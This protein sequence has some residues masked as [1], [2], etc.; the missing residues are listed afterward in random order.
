MKSVLGLLGIAVG[1]E[2]LAQD[3]NSFFP[4][5]ESPAS[6]RA[7]FVH[8]VLPMHNAMQLDGSGVDI[9]VWESDIP[10]VDHFAFENAAIE[11][12][13]NVENSPGTHATSVVG[14]MVGAGACQ[15]HGPAPGA[16]IRMFENGGGSTSVAT[17][18]SQWDEQLN[19]GSGLL[20]N[21]SFLAGGDAQHQAI[22]TSTFGH[23]EHL[24]IVGVGNISQNNWR[25]IANPHKNALVVG[26]I[27]FNQNFALGSSARGPTADGRIK[28][29]LV[30][31]GRGLQLP[32]LDASGEAVLAT[33]QGSSFACALACGQ[34]A[35]VQEWA[36]SELGAPLRGDEL[37]AMLVA[38]AE[39]LGPPGPDFQF[40]F[41]QMQLDKNLE[42]ISRIKADCPSAGRH[43]G[44]LSP[45]QSDTIEI[46]EFGEHPLRACLVWMDP[47]GGLA[48]RHV[49]NDLDLAVIRDGQ[50]VGLPWALPHFQTFIDHSD[51]LELLYNLP[52]IKTINHLD[53]VELV[54]LDSTEPGPHR[55]VV[56][57][58]GDAE[59]GFALVWQALTEAPWTLPTTE[60]EVLLCA[61]MDVDF[62][63]FNDEG[64]LPDASCGASFQPGSF[65]I[66]SSPDNGCMHLSS[67]EVMCTPCPGDMNGDGHRSSADLLAILPI[68]ENTESMCTPEC[69]N[70]DMANEN[71]LVA[72]DDLLM[73]LSIYGTPCP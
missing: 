15:I 6:S 9:L 4:S 46:P 72:V 40:G 1:G 60:N 68:Y 42:F 55:L 53:N 44:M 52:A 13:Y 22:E 18:L 20:T 14:A 37:K 50:V 57:N 34:S 30:E 56:S 47:P 24:L 17:R 64:P 65:L 41:G 39:D 51:S 32:A 36:I 73:F 16:S 70:F 71:L 61:E 8:G 66:E 3:L 29:D 11:I 63:V 5:L 7:A 26:S 59:Q 12:V 10:L 45:N 31:F 69:S 62:M 49:Q 35:L 27:D 28:P 33:G 21:W 19:N 48:E 58:H 2:C 25:R 38:C 67:F 43:L 23:P 54:D